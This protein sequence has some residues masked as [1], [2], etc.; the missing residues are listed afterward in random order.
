MEEMAQE[1]AVVAT[2]GAGGLAEEGAMA[3]VATLVKTQLV[4]AMVKIEVVAERVVGELTV[5]VKVRAASEGR[6]LIRRCWRQPWYQGSPRYF[7]DIRVSRYSWWP[8]RGSGGRRLK[9][10]SSGNT[11]A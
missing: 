4:S 11:L 9:Y 8:H 1:G 2:Q 3:N 6:Q 5:V 10:S 7:R